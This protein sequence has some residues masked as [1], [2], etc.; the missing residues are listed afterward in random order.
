MPSFIICSYFLFF[1]GDLKNKLK[2][3]S[4][5][6]MNNTKVIGNSFQGNHKDN[7]IESDYM[8]NRP[9]EDTLR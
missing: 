9:E 6:L 1:E 2:K 7:R 8:H 3:D 4:K 5:I